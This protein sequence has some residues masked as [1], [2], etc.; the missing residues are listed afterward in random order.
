IRDVRNFILDQV[1]NYETTNLNEK[2]ELLKND[3]AIH[4]GTKEEEIEGSLIEGSSILADQVI[5]GDQTL[6]W[7]FNDKGNVHTET[8]GAAIGME[9][10]AQAFAFATNDV[11]TVLTFDVEKTVELTN[12]V[13]VNKIDELVSHTCYYGVYNSR[14]E[15]IGSITMTD[16]PDNVSCGSSTAIAAATALWNE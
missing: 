2:K 11:E 15:R 8:S 14:G 16:V 7:V 12:S 6:W 10:R 1:S 9:I 4:I 5:K 3:I 13:D